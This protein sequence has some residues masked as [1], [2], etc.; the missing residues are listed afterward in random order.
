MNNDEEQLRLQEFVNILHQADKRYLGELLGK[1]A[2]RSSELDDQIEKTDRK[3]IQR[4]IIRSSKN[5]N[6]TQ[7]AHLLKVHRQTLYYWIKRG[8]LNPKRDSRNYPVCT[9][10]D[11]ENLIKW[12]NL[13]KKES[14]S[15]L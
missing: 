7:V 4:K 14:L 6:L 13:V 5:Y 3:I 8:W 10:L 1:K 15:T 12:R 2:D 9:V 11:I